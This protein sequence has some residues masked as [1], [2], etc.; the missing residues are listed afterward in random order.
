MRDIA[1]AALVGADVEAGGFLGRLPEVAVEGALAPEATAWRRE[2]QLAVGAIE[3][4]LG[5]KHPSESCR[6]RDDPPS[7]G[8]TVIGLRALEDL[9]LVGGTTDLERLAVEV[10]AP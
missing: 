7:V 1:V 8:L 5:F 2:E 10:F 6:H 3:A 4:D 9:A